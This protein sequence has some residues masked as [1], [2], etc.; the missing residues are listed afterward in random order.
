MKKTLST[1]LSL[2]IAFSMFS[3]S[4]LAA[5]T[6]TKAKSSKDFTDLMNL[7]NVTKEKYDELIATGVFDGIAEGT[8]GLKENMNRAQFAKVAALIFGLPVD[9][10]LTTSSFSDVSGDDPANGYAMPYIEA[11]VKAGITDGVA[12]GKYDPTGQVTKE[13]LAAFLLRGLGLEENAQNITAIQDAS[14]S[15]WANGY[16]ALALDRGLMSNSTNGTF[17]GTT[18]ASRELLA[19]AS[20]E[21]KYQIKS[22]FSGKYAIASMKATDANVLSIRLNGVVADTSAVTF[23]LTKNGL[24]V[25]DGYTTSWSA[26]KSTAMLTFYTKFDDASWTATLGGLSS[27]DEAGQTAKA[28]TV[29]EK[30]AKIELVTTSDTLPNNPSAKLRIDFKATNQYGKQSSVSAS[31][32][33]LHAS[34]GSVTPIGGE[35]AFYLTLPSTLN[36]DD[37]L[38]LTVIH[39]DSGTQANK[40]FTI[41]DARIVSKVELGDLLGTSGSVVSSIESN[42]YAYLDLKVYDQYGLRVDTLDELNKGVTVTFSDS[43]LDKGNEGESGAFV[44]N[45]VGDDAADLKLRAISDKVKDVVVTVFANGSGESVT[46]TV[47]IIATNVP[48]SVQF[49]TYS[50]T[51]AKGDA[52]SGDESLDAKLYLPLIVKDDQG[53]TLSAQDIYDN[54][55]K[56]TIY[57]SGGV[58]LADQPISNSGSNKGKIA[59]ADVNTKGSS[60]ITVQLKDNPQVQTQLKVNVNDERKADTIMFSQAPAKYMTAGTDNEM[61]IKLYDQYGS[62]LKYDANGQYLVRYSLTASGGDEAS[63]AATSLSS[64]QRVDE[65]DATSARKYVLQPTKIGQAVTRDFHLAADSSDTSNDSIYNKSFK[66][67]TA[68]DAKAANYTYKATLYKLDSTGTV[69]I[70]GNSYVEVNN[71]STTMEVLDPSNVNTNLTY[72]AYLDKSIDNTMLAADDF[73]S[74]GTG[75]QGASTMY[76]TY[77]PFTKEVKIRA[78]KDKGDEVKVSSNI[79]SLTSSDP[80][81]ADVAS[82]SKDRDSTHY[83]AG[84]KEG[85]AAVTVMFYDGKKNMQTSSLKV[86]TKKEAPAV[87]SLTLKKTG[88]S[89]SMADLQAGL[90]LWDAKL[91]EKLTALDQYG[92]EIVGENAPG[93]MNEEGQA[94]D[95]ML[96]RSKGVGYNGNELLKLSFY[97]SDISGANPDVVSV[98]ENTGFIQYTGAADDVTSFKVNV[99]AP[100]GEQASFDVD[101]K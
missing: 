100:S 72:E 75:A 35:Q 39:Q 47:P 56:F 4:A 46:K 66:F 49:G 16:V 1:I 74:V 37:R 77:K 94:N 31:E 14:V 23:A 76:D 98:D 79:V 64:A 92:D 81:V 11:I 54:R 9:M 55:D 60:I 19:M 52:P 15:D 80:Q 91:G 58:T 69:T 38:S 27:I 33:D 86:S 12:E 13:Q 65:S 26:D 101:V 36:R 6:T 40:V 88:K 67:Y 73:M 8:F 2:A 44:D 43:D 62:E 57:S 59:I 7:D 96:V 78:T 84:G 22:V 61:K 82:K 87:S 85:Q 29:K 90:Y 24:P 10:T 25:A 70:N 71:L 99:I 50:Y 83:I 41:G 51:L 97:V 28:T 3:S 20:Y 42:S 93:T 17:G 32:F 5:T 34:L 89:V 48:G 95:N 63:L 18:A 45:A 53:N 68:A 30:I 21:S